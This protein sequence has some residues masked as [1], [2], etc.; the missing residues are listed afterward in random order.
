M[1]AP[2]KLGAGEGKKQP[3]LQRTL[4]GI[5]HAAPGES[6]YTHKHRGGDK[7]DEKW[8]QKSDKNGTLTGKFL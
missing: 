6:N 7:D 1:L 2:R 5:A 8:C 4:C 3:V